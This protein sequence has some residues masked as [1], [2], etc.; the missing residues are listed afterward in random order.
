M[1]LLQKKCPGCQSKNVKVY[2][3]YMTRNHG[4]RQLY[5]CEGRGK[6]FSET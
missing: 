1:E 6:V 2:K 5:R 3:K 4:S